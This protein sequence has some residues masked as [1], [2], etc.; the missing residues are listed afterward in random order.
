MSQ[1]GLEIQI[2]N[3]K[4]KGKIQFTNF[5]EPKTLNLEFNIEVSPYRLERRITLGPEMGLLAQQNKCV[6]YVC[7]S[8]CLSSN[9][10]F[11]KEIYCRFDPTGALEKLRGKRLMFVGDSLQR[12]QWQ[13][14]VC[15]VESYIP[16][17]QKSMRRGRV[18]SVF[19]AKVLLITWAL[20][21]FGFHLRPGF[22]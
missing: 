20:L 22:R 18:L 19:R 6:I 12:G 21:E 15:L 10:Y 14:F 11:N 7:N 13:S 4:K 2:L 9:H 17:D 16:A 5:F 8:S 1:L 3:K